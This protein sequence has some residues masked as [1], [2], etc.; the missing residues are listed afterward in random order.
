M[1]TVQI[2]TQEQVAGYIATT[3]LY[4]PETPGPIS[5]DLYLLPK[6]MLHDF[7]EV[8]YPMIERNIKKSRIE[9]DYHVRDI[10][11]MAAHGT[12]QIWVKTFE[13]KVVGFLATQ[14]CQTP[15]NRN[16]LLWLGS[17]FLTEVNVKNLEK[18]E[19]WAKDNFGCTKTETFA[20]PGLAKHYEK[21]GLTREQVRCVRDIK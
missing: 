8:L 15:R 19:K 5:D 7:V 10:L 3:H 21:L 16:L 12:A 18:V 20:R 1:Q 14:I 11:L 13:S 2:G 4:F 17:G 6:Y 9:Q